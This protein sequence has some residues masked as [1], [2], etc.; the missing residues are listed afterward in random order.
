MIVISDTS[1]FIALLNINKI[2]LLHTLYG[3]IIIPNGVR[4]ELF[5]NKFNQKSI[6]ELLR[7]DY[8]QVFDLTDRILYHSLIQYL[9]AGES[10]AIALAVE[11]NADLLL[12]DEKKG[13]IEAEKQGLKVIGTLGILIDAKRKGLIS[14]LSDT[15]EEL[16]SKIGFRLHPSLIVK[17]KLLVGE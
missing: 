8:V 16:K 1:P 15:I 6:L 3:K 9:D 14:N 13:R 11:L 17:A 4:E 2:E 10:E 7:K 12:I 5:R